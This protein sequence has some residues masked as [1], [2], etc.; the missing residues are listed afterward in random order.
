MLNTVVST[1]SVNVILTNRNLQTIQTAS[2]KYRSAPVLVA[3]CHRDQVD[4]LNRALESIESQ[5][6]F[7][8]DLVQV[9]VLDDNSEH[10]QFNQLRCIADRPYITILTAHC[11]NAA[12]ARNTILDWADLQPSIKWVARLDADDELFEQ[13]SL[14]DLI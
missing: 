3:V 2:T 4:F 6:L 10:E 8:Q 5:S 14:K 7:V 9:V 1:T 12:Q 11:G 13:D